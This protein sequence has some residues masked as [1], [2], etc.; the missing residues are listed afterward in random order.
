MFKIPIDLDRTESPTCSVSR[1]S[2][3]AK[4]L[5]ECNLIIWDECTMAHRKGVEAVDRTLRDIR[6][7]DRPMGGVTVLFCGDFR[8]ILPVIPR[9]TR[10][11]EVRACLKSSY[12]WRDIQSL[13]LT[14]NMRVR[15][16]D[17]PDDSQFS[18]TLL[19]IGEGTYPQH[20]GKLILTPE[21][22]CIVQSQSHLISS[23]YGDV[24]N[25]LNR[26]NSWLCERSILT[27]RNDQASEINNQILSHIQGQ[28]KVYRSINRMVDE[29]EATNYPIEFLNSLNIPG[30]P[31]HEIYLKI[32]IPIILL[33]NLRPPKLCNGTRL[34][35][36]QLQQNIIEAQILTGCGAGEIVFIPRIPIIP[37][38]FPFQF[39]RTQFPVSV[40][41]AMTINKA[42]GQTFRVAGVDLG[43][44]CFSHGQ[45][46][47]AL[48]RVSSSRNLYVHVPDGSTFNIVY[49][50]ALR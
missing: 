24:T 37:N 26:D 11:D 14:T 27:P 45:L 32:G 3:K 43:V 47:V 1:N 21:L 46:Y 35:V 31:S 44:S 23:V 40:C 7:N 10:A 16:G 34:K 4:V 39:K 48:S 29:Q 49:P 20:Q 30:L 25:I 33:R 12:L 15:T 18:D 5:R 28:T 36:T 9:G 6:Q 17:N 38:N 50:E 13:H 42:Q 19:K 22:C 2:D 41:Y 8:Q